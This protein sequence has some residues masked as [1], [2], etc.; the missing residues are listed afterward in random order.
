ML[1]FM[2]QDLQSNQL[3]CT[4]IPAP[5]VKHVGHQIRVSESQNPQWYQDICSQ[6]PD[7]SHRRCSTVVRRADIKKYLKQ[8]IDRGWSV[9]KYAADLIE[10]ADRLEEEYR[11]SCE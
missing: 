11:E 6:Y 1:K 4:L 9:S 10:I 7:M 8:L 3:S 2:Y 5:E